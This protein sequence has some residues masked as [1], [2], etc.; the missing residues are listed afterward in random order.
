M[1]TTYQSKEKRVRGGE[2][3]GKGEEGG[4]R[5][6]EKGDERG[7]GREGRGRRGGKEILTIKHNCG[8]SSLTAS[9]A[10]FQSSPFNVLYNLAP[11]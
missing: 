10:F 8:W 2:G 9:P 7:R 5:R 4:E 11:W 1:G 6:R 3:E